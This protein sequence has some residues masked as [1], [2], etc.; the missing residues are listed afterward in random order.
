MKLLSEGVKITKALAYASGTAD[1]NG[2]T[3]DM[4][5]FEGVL[6]VVNFAT[7]AASGV[8]SIKAQ[9]GAA[10]NLSD[11]AD[12]AGTKQDVAVDDDDQIFVID[13]FR[14]L[15]RYVRVV[16]DKDGTNAAA[17]SAIY[18]QYGARSEP[19]VFAVDDLVNLEQFESP[20]EGTA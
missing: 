10:S 20:A 7:I 18:I 19:T 8:N 1:R 17:E 12:L 4:K 11:V 5:G 16:V 9:Q 15:E 14:P 3:L 13:V 2:A 6:M